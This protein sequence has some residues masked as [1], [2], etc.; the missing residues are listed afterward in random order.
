[1]GARFFASTI[2]MSAVLGVVQREDELEDCFDC[3]SRAFGRAKPLLNAL[4]P[5]HDTP[6]GRAKGVERLKANW[7]AHEED[8]T[9]F[10]VKASLDGR[11][12]GFAI[13]VLIDANGRNLPD[14]IVDKELE[15]DAIYDNDEEDAKEW[16]RQVWHA[17][18]QPRRA[19]CKDK[20][21]MALELCVVHPD[22]QR[23]GIGQM[24]TAWGVQRAKSNGAHMAV[25]EASRPGVGC[26]ARCGFVHS[27]PILFDDVD[28]HLV[29][30]VRP[31]PDLM[32]MQTDPLR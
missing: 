12:A 20:S 2:V 8:D 9:C 19:A 23:R 15:L 18:V 21:V 32:F 17:Y 7:R 25:V 16:L 14:Q 3:M 6:G 22:F 4:Y 13:W 24:L 31:L 11:V 5:L 27:E 1:M 26:Y 29:R 28:H 30:Q 10:F